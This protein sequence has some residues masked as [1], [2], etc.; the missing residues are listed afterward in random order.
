MIDI[1]FIF[2]FIVIQVNRKYELIFVSYSISLWYKCMQIWIDIFPYSISLWYKCMQNMDW[3]LLHISFH[4]DTNECKIWFGICSIYFIVI[5]LN[6]TY[7][8]VFVLYSISFGYKWMQNMYWHLFHVP[9][10]CDTN[11][12]KI[13]IDIFPY[14]IWFW[15]EWMQN[16]ASSKM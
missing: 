5:H 8:L 3:Y 14:S 16:V 7:G 10:H 6:A 9:F 13:S 1:C 15:Y 11:A 4:F 12:C 2:H